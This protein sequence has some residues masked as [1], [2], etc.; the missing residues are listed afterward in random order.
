[1]RRGIEYEEQ[2]RGG[3]RN[4]CF[5]PSLKIRYAHEGLHGSYM[6]NLRQ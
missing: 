1:M 5:A 4:A 3:E 6:Q 2:K